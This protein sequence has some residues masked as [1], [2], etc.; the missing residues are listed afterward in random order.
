M[1]ELAAVASVVGL[2]SLAFQ[3]FKGCVQAFDFFSSAQQFSSDGD[4]IRSKMQWEQHRLMEWGARAGLQSEPNERLDWGFIATLLQQQ[5]ALLTS[6]QKLKEKYNLNI[7]EDDMAVAEGVP[8]SPG[9]TLGRLL[10]RLKPDFY[11]ATARV[12]S[13][14]NGPVKKLRWAAVGKDQANRIVSD[15]AYFN[16]RLYKLLELADQEYIHSVMS[17]LLR[18]II[19]RSTDSSELNTVKQLLNPTYLPDGQ[20]ISAAA[21]LKQIRLILGADKRSDEVKTSPKATVPGVR[22]EVKILTLR[23]L[24]RQSPSAPRVG[25]EFALYRSKQVLVE[26]RAVDKSLWDQLHLPIEGLAVVLSSINDPSF[27]SLSCCG[28]LEDRDHDCCA[29]IYNAPSALT[30]CKD[31]LPNIWPLRDLFSQQEEPSLSQRFRIANDLGET[32]LQLHTSGWLHKGIRSENV[33]F[34]APSDADA[35]EAFKGQPYLAGY[36][37]AREDGPNEWTE[38]PTTSPEADLYRHPEARGQG[39]MSFRKRFD[40]YSLGCVLLELAL[41]SELIE[42]QSTHAGVDL[43]QTITTVDAEERDLRMPSMLG[44]A[45]DKSLLKKISYYVGSTFCDVIVMCLTAEDAGGS[46]DMPEASLETQKAIVE[47]LRSCKC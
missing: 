12:I 8:T 7:E 14:N 38:M 31:R 39:R 23:K 30:I 4:V 20:A 6:A 16:S 46:D 15:I 41:W 33:L 10:F 25:T 19:S 5:E 3:A 17:A 13:A 40:L 45:H 26:W 32:V 35:E 34:L 29:L 28:Y 1:A 22:P 43:R 37:Y 36:E 2:I 42:I 27:H 9:T 21:S 47:K 44:I 18:D 24:I 11:L